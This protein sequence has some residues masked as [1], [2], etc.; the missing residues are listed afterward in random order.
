MWPS[1]R[2][3]T[4]HDGIEAWTASLGPV[5]IAL[6]GLGAIASL[7]GIGVAL[8]WYRRTPGER[9]RRLLANRDEVAVLMHPNPDPDAM[10]SAMAVAE[11]ADSVDTD[12]TL[13]YP[14]EIRH[15]ENRAF[16]TVLGLDFERIE[17][18]ADIVADEVVLVDHNA[19]R[20]FD[21]ASSVEPTAVVDHHPGNG[22]GDDF[23]DVRTDYGACATILTEYLQSL[24]VEPNG[25]SDQSAP[26]LADETAT[27]LLY[28]VQSDTNRLTKGCSSAEFD[29]CAFLYPGVNQAVLDRIANPQV[30]AGVLETKARAIC[31]RQ[32]RGSFAVCDV[33]EVP[34][35]DAIPQAADELTSLEGVTAVVVYGEH[36]GTLHLSGRSRDD[37]VHMG[38]AL[39]AVVGDIPMANAGGHARMGG[40][41]VSVEHMQGIGPS[42]G[43]SRRE[44]TDRLFGALDGDV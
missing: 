5:E 44:L 21:G 25:N 31:D 9:F 37:R 7:L 4:F 35:V 32:V 11:I 18:A 17:S 30:S 14:G 20:G 10:S 24:G 27:G 3:S 39:R 34:V 12:T 40:G 43:I 33:G 16:Q 15:Q 42:D 28:G 36:E 8:R 13:Q 19:A 23:T 29:A 41:Q 1:I 6:I 2:P 38:E 26:S 22:T